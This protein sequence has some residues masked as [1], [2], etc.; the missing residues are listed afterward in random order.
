[1]HK[2]NTKIKIPMSPVP[3]ICP[4]FLKLCFF[5][6]AIMKSI[7]NIPIVLLELEEA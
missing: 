6:M 4:N 1:M 5:F 3:E 2:R 7:K